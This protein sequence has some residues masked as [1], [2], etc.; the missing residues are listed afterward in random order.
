[1]L[2][3]VGN[4]DELEETEGDDY[5]D[6][7]G[8]LGMAQ[9]T[10]VDHTPYMTAVKDQSTCGSCWAFAATSALEG[11]IGVRDGVAPPRLSE[12]QNVDCTRGWPYYLD[13]CNG[14]WMFTAWKYMKD[15]GV[16]TNEDY[17]YRARDQSCA[18]DSSKVYGR[19]KQYGG[20]PRNDVYAMKNKVWRQPVAVA[21]NGDSPAFRFYKSGVLR[22]CCDPA[23]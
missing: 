1:M 21:L 4:D 7:G 12:Q 3:F 2:G 17:P 22:S 19:V 6:Y 18:Y 8:L 15:K 16:M 9:A 14:G 5:E 10:A 23:N 11:T 20:T 13:G